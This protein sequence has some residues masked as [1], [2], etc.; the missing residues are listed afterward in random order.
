ML[1]IR[2]LREGC[3][4]LGT[5]FVDERSEVHKGLLSNLPISLL[6][7]GK[8]GCIPP[9]RREGRFSPT[10][11]KRRSRP[12]LYLFKLKKIVFFYLNFFLFFKKL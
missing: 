11:A 2:V 6:I 8:G 9:N 10:R 1:V 12:K 5:A 3:E 7:G 4:G